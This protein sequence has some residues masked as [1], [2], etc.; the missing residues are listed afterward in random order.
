VPCRSIYLRSS[1]L[2]WKRILQSIR[3][4]LIDNKRL[5][6]TQDD[7]VLAGDCADRG[8]VWLAIHGDLIGTESQSKLLAASKRSEQRARAR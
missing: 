4:Q 8:L 5:P 3:D 7:F 1:L 6:R 2:P